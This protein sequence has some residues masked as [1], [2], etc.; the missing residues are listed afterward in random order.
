MTDFI[1]DKPCRDAKPSHEEKNRSGAANAAPLQI[2]TDS[3]LKPGFPIN[4][5]AIQSSRGICLAFT[6]GV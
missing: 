4:S 5:E 1:P 6:A 2:D 3:F